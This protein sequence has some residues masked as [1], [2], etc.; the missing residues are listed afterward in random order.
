LADVEASRALPAIDYLQGRARLA[1][2]QRRCAAAATGYDILLC[3]SAPCPPVRIDGPDKT[4]RM[5]ALTKPFNA[6][7]WPALSLPAGFD[8]DGL[9]LGLQVVGLPGNDA[10]VLSAAAA[11]ERLLQD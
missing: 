11:L 10:V 1:E 7:G 4:T 6:L 8:R 2:A 3:A 5:N 9:P